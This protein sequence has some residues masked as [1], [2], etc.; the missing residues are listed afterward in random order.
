M[1]EADKKS[2]RKMFPHL[3]RELTD[4]KNTVQIDSMRTTPDGAEKTIADR[5]HEYNPNVT[6]FIRRCSTEKEA[7]EI[8]SFLEGRCEI[9]KE[10]AEELRGQLARK[11]VR[12]FGSKKEEGYYFKQ[13]GLC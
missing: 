4:G 12:S 10:Q 11:G 3:A 1:A 5:F 7:E 9:S 13:S 6:D 8:I 2:F